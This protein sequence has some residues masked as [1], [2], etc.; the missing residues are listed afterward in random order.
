MV[1]A[2]GQPADP[3]S[4]A[5]RKPAAEPSAQGRP[6]VRTHR[7]LGAIVITP[8]GVLDDALLREVEGAMA[9][10][11][12]VTVVLEL[13]ACALTDLTGLERLGDPRWTPARVRVVCPRRSAR[14]MLARAG[15][16]SRLPIFSTLEQAI[17]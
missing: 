17:A 9:G 3:T 11:E 14:R 12:E 1:A 10:A 5:Q 4:R 8:E 6:A 7:I 13:S 16:A 2:F 15:V